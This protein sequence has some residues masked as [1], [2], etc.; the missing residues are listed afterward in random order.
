M[1]IGANLTGNP[2]AERLI[3]DFPWEL[4]MEIPSFIRE[5]SPRNSLLS[6]GANE[7]TGPTTSNGPLFRDKV[8]SGNV[9]GH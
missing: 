6:P 3:W 7:Q 2:I 8:I 1:D 9:Y 5:A 4:L